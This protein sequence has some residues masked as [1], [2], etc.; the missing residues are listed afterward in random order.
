VAPTPEPGMRGEPRTAWVEQPDPDAVQAGLLP[1]HDETGR[2][3]GHVPADRAARELSR[4]V[5]L[6]YF[7]P[8]PG[9]GVPV[10]LPAGGAPLV[11]VH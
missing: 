8:A 1:V 11:P 3:E 10:P 5:Y 6:P 4:H 7:G 9:L 2:I